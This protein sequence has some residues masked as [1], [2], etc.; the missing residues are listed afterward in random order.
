M[1]N[2]LVVDDRYVPSELG[3]FAYEVIILRFG[4]VF[5]IHVDETN[6]MPQGDLLVSRGA[7]GLD[8]VIK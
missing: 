4:S 2:G 8:A 6:I 5:G 1:Y 3:D 7:H